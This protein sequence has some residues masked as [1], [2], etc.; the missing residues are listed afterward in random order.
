MLQQMVSFFVSWFHYPSLPVSSLLISIALGIAFGAVWL[1][2]LWPPLKRYWLW[3]VMAAG[4][5]LGLASISFIQIPLQAYA[6]DLLS[7][8]WSQQV[9]T[10]WILLAGVPQILL[11][12]L[13]QEG[14]KMLPVVAWW[15]RSDKKIDPKMGLIIG[16]FAG[17]GFGIFEAVWVHNSAFAAGWTWQVVQINGITGLLVF[18]ER[19]LLVGFH[20][21]AAAIVGYGLA[22]GWGWQS[23]LIASL[24]HALI[25]Y[26]IVLSIARV[27][28]GMQVEVY[29]FALAILIIAAV[30]WLRWRRE[31]TEEISPVD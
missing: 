13:V 5:L 18:I 19:F 30:I 1:A 20:I 23:Y 22:K 25:N 28:T 11:S 7:R 4:A 8:I 14:A 29:I 15:W 2:C 12:G 3:V 21:S 24:L 27:F 6:G 9:L 17:A 10:N 31:P 16:A 26:S